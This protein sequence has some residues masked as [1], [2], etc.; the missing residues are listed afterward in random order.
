MPYANHE[1]FRK[2]DVDEDREEQE[3][4]KEKLI[5]FFLFDATSNVRCGLLRVLNRYLPKRVLMIR[6]ITHFQCLTRLYYF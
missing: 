5:N 2:K 1:R 6:S 4:S 3:E